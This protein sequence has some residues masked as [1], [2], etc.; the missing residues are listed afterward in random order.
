MNAETQANRQRYAFKL[1]RHATQMTPAELTALTSI[2]RLFRADS[3]ALAPHAREQAAR[4]GISES[5]IREALQ[6]G[7]PVELN[8]DE[9][10]RVNV[11][12]RHESGTCVVVGLTTR[13]IVTTYFNSPTDQ[14]RTLDKSLN[15]WAVNAAEVAAAELKGR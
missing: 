11:L 5:A 7:I 6:H 15:T 13:R 9:A 2:V 8:K 10:N 3:Y 14:H 12:L 1:R 4:K